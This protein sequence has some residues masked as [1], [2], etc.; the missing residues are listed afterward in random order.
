M[1]KRNRKVIKDIEDLYI[2]NNKLDQIEKYRTYIVLYT[3]LIQ[4]EYSFQ[5]PMEHL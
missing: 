1:D 5:M 2:N 4:N 3:Q